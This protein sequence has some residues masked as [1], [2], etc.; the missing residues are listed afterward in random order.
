MAKIGNLA[1]N[2]TQL[3][4]GR[5]AEYEADRYGV[6]FMEGGRLRGPRS[7]IFGTAWLRQSSGGENPAILQLFSTHPPT[8][9]RIKRI[10]ALPIP[11][12][13]IDFLLPLNSG[14][15][16]E[17]NVVNDPVDMGDF[18]YD[19]VGDSGQHLRGET[20]PIGGCSVIGWLRH[21]GPRCRRRSVGRP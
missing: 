4:Y 14:W 6:Y 7:R 12:C 3:G 17:G 13:K 5:E 1:I 20:I 15:G 10:K 2:L 19:P 16:F 9:E 8:A 21:G 11:L 18:V